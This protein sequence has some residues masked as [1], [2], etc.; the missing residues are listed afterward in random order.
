MCCELAE[1]WH[2]IIHV[3][4]WPEINVRH[5]PW[6]VVWLLHIGI[7][8]L[9]IQ[10]Q[11]KIKHV[12]LLLWYGCYLLV[13]LLRVL[14]KLLH[15]YKKH[16]YCWIWITYEIHIFGGKSNT[17]MRGL[18]SMYIMTFFVVYDFCYA[19]V[20]A[21]I[22]ISHNIVIPCFCLPYFHVSVHYLYQ[23]PQYIPFHRRSFDASYDRNHKC[24]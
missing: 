9:R 17:P 7:Y 8:W 12:Y 10:S 22:L 14:F 16:L 1:F 3:W 4:I 6:Q 18:S 2:A 5:V 13:D 21:Y 24:V 11:F 15:N 19:H 23:V 20:F